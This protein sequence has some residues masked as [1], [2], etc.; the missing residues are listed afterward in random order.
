MVFYLDIKNSVWS[1]HIEIGY[2][3]YHNV[4]F[5]FL[6]LFVLAEKMLNTDIVTALSKP[7]SELY[8]MSYVTI[9]RSIKTTSSDGNI[10]HIVQVFELLQ[11]FVNEWTHSQQFC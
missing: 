7:R 2:L 4:V 1:L 10:R 5:L 9:W 11:C 8:N 3:Q 6:L